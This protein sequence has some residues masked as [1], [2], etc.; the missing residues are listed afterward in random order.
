VF[1]S[2]IFKEWDRTSFSTK[3]QIFVIL[4][5]IIEISWSIC[6]YLLLKFKKLVCRI[7]IPHY[8]LQILKVSLNLEILDVNAGEIPWKYPYM[9]L[10]SLAGGPGL[11]FIVHLL[12]MAKT[13]DFFISNSTDKGLLICYDFDCI[14][15]SK[16]RCSYCEIYVMNIYRNAFE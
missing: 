3:I 8:D 15:C 12:F 4:L 2:N 7:F 13:Y 10:A 6:P 5:K 9:G 14:P 1:I 16:S 11:F